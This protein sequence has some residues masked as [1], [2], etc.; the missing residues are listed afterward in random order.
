MRITRIY[1]IGDGDF[2]I[3]YL[4]KKNSGKS[5]VN[6]KDMNIYINNS[7]DSMPDI[8]EGLVLTVKK[9]LNLFD[10][11]FLAFPEGD[12]L[13]S[14]HTC[15]KGFFIKVIR[16]GFVSVC[17]K[18]SLW[19]PILSSILTVSDKGSKGEREDRSGPALIDMLFEIGAVLD[20]RAIVPDEQ[21]AIKSKIIE[22]S[23]SGS[24]L[25]L[26]TGGTGVS[27]RDVTPEAILSLT[28]RVIPG[29]GESMRSKTASFKST[30]FLSRGLAATYR[31]TLI[32]AFPGS[33]RGAKECF[34]AVAPI[35]R[36]AVETLCGWTGECGD[37]RLHR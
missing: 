19:R 28:N 10:G 24:R 8:S 11:C 18:I 5:S 37:N 2:G 14:V 12:P 30:A 22:W 33:E 31:D 1:S 6:G 20:N 16:P 21:E 36:H 3:S 7:S 27:Q 25:I 35:L 29:I 17:Q 4:H 13:L 32:V 34:A 15:E 9:D 23:K 26:L